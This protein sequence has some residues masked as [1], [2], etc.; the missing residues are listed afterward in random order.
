MKRQAVLLPLLFLLTYVSRAIQPVCDPVCKPSSGSSTYTSNV[1]ARPALP[2]ARGVQTS[3]APRV[4]TKATNLL[5]SQS[6]SQAVPILSLPGRNGL[7][8]NLTLYYNS[9]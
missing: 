8:L 7:N 1:Q 2:N 5:G 6:F 3:L 4:I 9:H